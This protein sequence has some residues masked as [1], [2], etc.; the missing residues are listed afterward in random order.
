VIREILTTGDAREGQEIAGSVA[1]F[2]PVTT[3]LELEITTFFGT[4]GAL[5]VQVDTHDVDRL[6]ININD[7]T[8]YDRDIETDHDYGDDL[9]HD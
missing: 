9:D 2:Q 5:V 3:G 1:V 7:G 6:R 8:V 4:D